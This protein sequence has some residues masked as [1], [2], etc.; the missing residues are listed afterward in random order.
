[1]TSRNVPPAGVGTRAKISPAVEAALWALSNGRC[2][3]PHCTVPVVLETRPGIYRKNVQIAHIYGVK[4]DAARHVKTM[5]PKERDSFRNLL[6][7]CTAHH[8]DVDDKHTGATD[9]PP[10][11]LKEW[12]AKREGADGPLLARLR[13]TETDADKFLNLLSGLFSPPLDRLEA[14]TERLERT[15]E[16]TERT[17]DELRGVLRA[18]AANE[19]AVSHQSARQLATAAEMFEHQNLNRAAQL[20]AHSVEVLPEL[21]RELNTVARRL[22]EH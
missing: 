8:A 9:F 13:I 16:V 4:P 10:E 11:L 12:K 22:P 17:V 6:L 21:I 20:L 1:M 15:G 5:P 19:G 3:E 2:Y 14:I 18:L 7:L